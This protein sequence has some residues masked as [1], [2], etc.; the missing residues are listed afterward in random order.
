MKMDSYKIGTR[1]T[2][3]YN[4]SVY[5]SGCNGW[6]A[7]TVHALMEIVSPAMAVVI[8][9]DM[10][11]AGSHRQE[12]NHVKSANDQRGVRKRLSSLWNVEVV[13]E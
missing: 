5:K 4:A 12:Y 6:R 8:S 2:A 7:E 1:I 13:G 9:A 10:D 3:D 11:P